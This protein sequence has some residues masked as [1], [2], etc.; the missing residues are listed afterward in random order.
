MASVKNAP[1]VYYFY[2]NKNYMYQN[3]NFLVVLGFFGMDVLLQQEGVGRKPFV[4]PEESINRLA[5]QLFA[6]TKH[7][8]N[9]VCTH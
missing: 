5:R 6:M 7:T 2:P 1:I 8:P 3:L 4:S 9:L